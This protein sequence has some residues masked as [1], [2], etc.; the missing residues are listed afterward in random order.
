MAI[1][2]S[3]RLCDCGDHAFSGLTRNGVALVSSQDFGILAERRWTQTFKGYVDSRGGKLHRRVARAAP[4]ELVDHINHD[5]LDCRRENLRV[6]TDAQSIRNR[7]KLRRKSSPASP[8][9]GVHRN[10]AG[11]IA[12]ICIGGVRKSVGTFKTDTE[13]AEAY[14]QAARVHIGEYAQLNFGR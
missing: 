6:V 4:G 5:K 7:R 10:G 8:Y 3:A 13:A 11:W 9:I 1:D 2:R 14:D 12:R